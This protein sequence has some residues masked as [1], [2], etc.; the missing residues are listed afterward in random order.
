VSFGTYQRGG[1]WLALKDGCFKGK[2]FDMSVCIIPCSVPGSEVYLILAMVR[3]AESHHLLQRSRKRARS[4][5]ANM[6]AYEE[7][8]GRVTIA[9]AGEAGKT[10]LIVATKMG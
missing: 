10:R 1:Q 9:K 6:S 2:G 4:V 7:H 5:W 8:G 3:R